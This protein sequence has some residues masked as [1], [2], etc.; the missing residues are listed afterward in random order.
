[1]KKILKK[2][3]SNPERLMDIL[4]DIQDKEGVISSESIKTIASKLKLSVADVQKT[5]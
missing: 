2:Y 4:I 3:A 1:M 5:V